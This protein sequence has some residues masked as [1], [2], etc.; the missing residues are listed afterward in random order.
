MSSILTK[1][2]LCVRVEIMII[3]ERELKPFVLNPPSNITR[4]RDTETEEK[5]FAFL[6]KTKDFGFDVETNI[7]Q[8]FF[9]RK[10][11]TMQFG[12]AEA[13]YVIDLKDYC[14][15]SSDILFSCQ[16]NYGENL[17]LRAPK[18]YELLEKLKKYLCSNEWTKTGVNLGFEHECLYWMFGIRAYGWYDCMMA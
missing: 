12:T 9:W 1:K 6:E 13:Q 3:S 17:Q 16:G 2:L 18:F 11:R 15:G 4:V 8:D 14:D 7:A 5:L 10:M